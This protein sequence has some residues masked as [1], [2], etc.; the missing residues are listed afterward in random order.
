[1][2]HDVVLTRDEYRSMADGLADSTAPASGTIALS[3]WV[4]AHADRL[5]RQWSNELDRHFR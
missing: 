2:L 1:V 3:A 5:G 4:D